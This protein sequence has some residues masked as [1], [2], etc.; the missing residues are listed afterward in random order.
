LYRQNKK[1]HRY[2]WIEKAIWT[3]ATVCPGASVKC[4]LAELLNFWPLFQT[5]HGFGSLV[6]TVPSP[7]FQLLSRRHLEHIGAATELFSSFLCVF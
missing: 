6:L 2:R 5:G 4:D 3:L 1:N 7:I